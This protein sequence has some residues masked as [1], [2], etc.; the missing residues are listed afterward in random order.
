MQFREIDEFAARQ[1]FAMLKETPPIRELAEKYP[2]MDNVI[3]TLTAQMSTCF[4]LPFMEG[5][6]SCEDLAEAFRRYLYTAFAF[7]II[8]RNNDQAT[9]YVL[10]LYGRVEKDSNGK[11]HIS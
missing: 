4:V 8:M 6:M 1:F 7:G 11:D 2:G 10:D 5:R 9:R 3:H